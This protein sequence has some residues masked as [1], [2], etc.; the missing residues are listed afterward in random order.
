MEV[1]I[2]TIHNHLNYGAVLQAYALNKAVQKMGYQCQIIN[3]NFEPGKGRQ[4]STSKHMGEQIKNLYLGWHWAANKRYREKFLDFERQHIPIT[5]TAYKNLG[6]LTSKP[7]RFDAYIAGSDQVWHPLLLE[8]QIGKAFHLCFV[9]PEKS[10]LIAYAPSFGVNE[11]PGRYLEEIK[12][13]L[14]RY[15][16][17]SARERKGQ[18]IIFALTGMKAEHVVD[19]TFLLSA[20]EY[21]PVLQSPS[22]SDEYILVYP[23]ELG[24]DGVFLSLVKEVKKQLSLPII[25]VLPRSF[26][27]RWLLISD[28]VVLDAGP[29][30]FLGLCKHSSLICTNSFHGT[31]FSLIYQKDFLGVPHTQTNSRIYGILERLDLCRRQITSVNSTRIREILQER[32]DYSQVTPVLQGCIQ[33]SLKYLKNALDS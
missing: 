16:A 22:Y 9:S 5:D 19:P 15:H 23:M 10:R 3:C 30:E 11:I 14:L 28:K 27:Y 4:F 20:A 12:K 13:Y 31:A 1:G 17:L 24:E 26:S 18:E 7:P 8:R 6:Q 2:I 32:I 25:C 29:K 33:Q 21:E